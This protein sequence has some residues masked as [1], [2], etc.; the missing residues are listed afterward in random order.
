MSD[1]APRKSAAERSG[2]TLREKRSAKKAKRA[3]KDTPPAVARH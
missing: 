3:G 2:R 1:K